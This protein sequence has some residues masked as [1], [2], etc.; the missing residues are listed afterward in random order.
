MGMSGFFVVLLKG[1][2]IVASMKQVKFAGTTIRVAEADPGL[3]IEYSMGAVL[4]AFGDD[5][6]LLKVIGP[7]R[8]RLGI[9]IAWS[10]PPWYWTL[11]E[12]S[13]APWYRE[14]HG[15][16]LMWSSIDAHATRKVILLHSWTR[17]RTFY[18]ASC[19]TPNAPDLTTVFKNYRGDIGSH[20]CHFGFRW[21]LAYSDSAQLNVINAN[22]AHCLWGNWGNWHSRERR[23][24]GIGQKW[25]ATMKVFSDGRK[26]SF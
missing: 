9:H 18:T 5:Q 15:L 16:L 19:E 2:W 23:L 20:N 3:I 10:V 8:Q 11:R 26:G 1:Y 21:L 4:N 6:L 17:R 7:H 24:N 14:G 25:W 22:A 12:N 13:F